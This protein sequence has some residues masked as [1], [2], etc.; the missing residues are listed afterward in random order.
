MS[1]VIR[2]AAPDDLDALETIEN[3]VFQGDRLSRRAMRHHVGH[4][5]NVLVVVERDGVI[6]GYALVAL[7]SGS[8]LARL[9]SIALV[10]EAS[11]TGLGARLLDAAEQAAADRGAT[12]M[13]LEVRADNAAAIRLYERCGYRRFGIL[14]SYYEDGQD[15]LRFEKRLDP[16]A[17]RLDAAKG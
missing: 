6:L 13:R 7:R 14:P 11:G 17:S 3:A 8:A 2:P 4:R 10:P 1:P 15:A 9:Y 12:A 5:R 16:V